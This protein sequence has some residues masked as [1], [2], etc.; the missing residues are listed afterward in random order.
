MVI[1][2][3]GESGV[4]AAVLAARNGFEVFLSEGGKLADKYKEELDRNN[5]SYEQVGHKE[6]K[7]LMADEI[8]KSPGIS[9]KN[10]LVK[11]IRQKGIKVSS[12]IELAYRYKGNSRIVAITGTNGKTTTTTMTY[13]ICEKG[14]ID[15]AL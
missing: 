1:L 2:G 14:G 10:E 5:L 3:G 13:R 9:E 12:E 15:C 6:E 8:I 4:G 11:K 7:I